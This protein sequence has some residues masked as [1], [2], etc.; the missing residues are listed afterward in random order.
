[1][2]TKTKPFKVMTFNI[3]GWSEKW[4]DGINAWGN[5]ARLTVETIKNVSPDQIGF[6]EFS[7][8]KNLEVYRR[9]LP[10]LEFYLGP[11]IGGDRFNPLAFNRQH[12]HVES[13]GGLWLTENEDQNIT[14]DASELRAATYVLFEEKSSRKKLL[15]LNTHLDHISDLARVEGTKKIL[16]LLSRFPPRIPVVALG[17]F[18]SS[19]YKP[20]QGAR[21]ST[22]PYELFKEHGFQD[23]F[24]VKHPEQKDSPPTTFHN[25]EGDH[26][27]ADQYGTWHNDWILYRGL[28]LQSYRIIQTAEPPL[29]PSDHYPVT[30]ALAHN[31]KTRS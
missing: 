6:Q 30:A 24:V 22:R 11:R 21:Y 9:L 3:R 4:H 8:S 18:N 29:Y 23:A 27:Q 17:D 31:R 13:G 19:Y 5:R 14:W 15:M 7:R 28:S 10:D 1:M 26:Y 20:H 16:Q 2:S 12:F 25:Y